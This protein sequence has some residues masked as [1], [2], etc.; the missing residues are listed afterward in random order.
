MSETKLRG[1]LDR[2]V[3]YVEN[4]IATTRAKIDGLVRSIW[5]DAG[6]L[7]SHHKN[8]GADGLHVTHLVMHVEE[9]AAAKDELTRLREQLRDLRNVIEFAER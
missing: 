4:E 9:L 7:C 5:R 6:D 8:V 1:A 2:I 3:Q